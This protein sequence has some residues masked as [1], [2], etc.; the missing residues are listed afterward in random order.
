MKQII[1]FLIALLLSSAGSNLQKGTASFYGKS[2]NGRRTS[3]GEILHND[4]L[5]AA[6][7]TLPF[8]TIV[9]VVNLKNDSVVMVKIIDRMSKKSSR[10]IDLTQAAAK[11]L[12]F[13]QAGLTTVTLEVIE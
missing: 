8:G 2:L 12:N 1:P 7:K 3:S 11:Q 4:S 13:I 5:Y 6:H 9:R 10:I